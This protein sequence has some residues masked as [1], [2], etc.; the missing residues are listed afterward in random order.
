MNGL[1]A[2]ESDFFRFRQKLFPF[3]TPRLTLHDDAPIM[4]G[5]FFIRIR[6]IREEE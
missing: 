2:V 3:S 6:A 5:I 4:A 1:D